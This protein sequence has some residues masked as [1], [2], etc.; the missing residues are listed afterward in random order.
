[1]AGL[2]DAAADNRPDLYVGHFHIGRQNFVPAS[3]RGMSA[4]EVRPE[5]EVLFWADIDLPP[6]LELRELTKDDLH[7]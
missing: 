6:G 5:L 2:S 3:S 1:L 4:G 7:G